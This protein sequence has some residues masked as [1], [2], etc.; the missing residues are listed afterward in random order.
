M[1]K[2]CIRDNVAA[3]IHRHSSPGEGLARWTIQTRTYHDSGPPGRLAAGCRRYSG[4]YHI[5]GDTIHP[6][7]LYVPRG[8]RQGADEIVV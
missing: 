5:S 6:H 3:M 1:V 7:R 4:E 8:G 2:P